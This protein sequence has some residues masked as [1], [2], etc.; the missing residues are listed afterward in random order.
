MNAPVRFVV[1]FLVTCYVSGP[2]IAAEAPALSNLLRCH[3][4]AVGGEALRDAGAVEYALEIEEP[5]FRVTA[6][7][8]AR[9][10]DTMRIDIYSDGT[11]VFSEGLWKGEGWRL[12]QGADEPA[13]TSPEG[14]AALR[15]GLEGPG[16]L[17]TL[18]DVERRGHRLRVVDR[19]VVDGAHHTVLELTFADGF[20]TWYWVEEDTC[21]VVRSRDFRAFHPEQDPDRVWVETVYD[22]FR[23]SDGVTRPHRSRNVNLATGD[24]LATTRITA[25]ELDPSLAADALKPGPPR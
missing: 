20:Q 10:P 15:H 16:R 5:G 25:V 14:T 7:Y 9:R 12:A 24:V 21:H 6:V 13:P 22:D 8:R 18:A 2:A 4:R 11:R 19:E 23:T 1:C 3:D 17:W